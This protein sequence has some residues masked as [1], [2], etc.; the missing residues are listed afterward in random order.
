M[1]KRL[2]FVTLSL[3]F[4]GLAFALAIGALNYIN[5]PD[6]SFYLVDLGFAFGQT[7]NYV[8]VWHYTVLNLLFAATIL[9]LVSVH[10]LGRPS[11]LRSLFAAKASRTDLVARA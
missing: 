6:H 2:G 10:T 8:Y 11:A 4:S 7:T 1:I 3:A 5:H 9:V